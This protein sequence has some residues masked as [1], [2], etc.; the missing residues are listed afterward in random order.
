MKM[1]TVYC[2]VCR[3]RLLRPCFCGIFH[4]ILKNVEHLRVTTLQS[5]TDKSDQIFGVYLTRLR[6]AQ[7]AVKT[8]VGV[9]WSRL[10]AGSPRKLH[11]KL[12]QSHTPLCQSCNLFTPGVIGRFCRAMTCQH[13]GLSPHLTVMNK[14]CSNKMFNIMHQQEIC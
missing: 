10:N 14:I 12:L 7:T 2:C 8:D 5:H 6:R 13:Q 3:S 1:H 9:S 11:I 4:F